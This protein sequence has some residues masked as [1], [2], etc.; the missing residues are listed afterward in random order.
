MGTLGCQ[1]SEINSDTFVAFHKSDGY[2]GHEE[3]FPLVFVF[4][5]NAFYQSNG[6]FCFTFQVKATHGANKEVMQLSAT[7]T[8]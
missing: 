5:T 6:F 8:A 1:T 7:F 2:D 3:L 4:Q